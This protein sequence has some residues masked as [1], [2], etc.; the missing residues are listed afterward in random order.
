MSHRAPIEATSI[1]AFLDT[2]SSDSPTPGGGATAALTAA[3]AA[4][5][6]AMVCRLTLGKR[7]YA[8][9]AEI[10]AATLPEAE[11]LCTSCLHDADADA[12]A[13]EAVASAMRLPKSD[14]SR[15]LTLQASLHQAAIVPAQLAGRGAAILSLVVHLVGK[16]NPHV[17]S[18]LAVAVALASASVEAATA[19][20]EANLALM[21][22]QQIVAKLRENVATTR[23]TAIQHCARALELLGPHVTGPT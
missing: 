11:A 16:S 5:L 12:E 20:V 3:M 22:D 15:H 7:R 2:L 4:G 17:A 6:V 21:D 8:A 1:R 10:A 18:D 23:I 13:Y 19:N 9:F 14:A